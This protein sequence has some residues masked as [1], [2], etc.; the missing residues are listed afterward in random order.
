M[1]IQSGD[2]GRRRCGVD[3]LDRGCVGGES[4]WA[5]SATKFQCQREKVSKDNVKEWLLRRLEV[6]DQFEGGDAVGIVQEVVEGDNIQQEGVVAVVVVE[7]EEGEA[8]AEA[9]ADQYST[10]PGWQRNDQSR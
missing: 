6:Q 10:A 1:D 8:E 7:E 2:D 3:F 4:W 9:E 5:C